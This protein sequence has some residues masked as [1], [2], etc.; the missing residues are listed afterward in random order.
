[1][2]SPKLEVF[3]LFDLTTNAILTGQVP[4]FLTY[5][6]DLGVNVAQPTI[7]EIGGGLYGFLPAFTDGRGIGYIIDTGAN[8]NP[9]RISRYMR[10]EDYIGED[11][12]DFVRGK[13][14]IKATGPDANR[15]IVYAPD[16]VTVLKKYDLEDVLGNPTTTNP[17]SRTPV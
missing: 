6:N 2:A 7:S 14:E 15:F 17:F 12:N 5:K 13:W 9:T 11:V 1:M 16:G 3:A 10:A 4:T 8:A